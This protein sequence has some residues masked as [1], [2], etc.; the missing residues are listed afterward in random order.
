M[1]AKLI[2]DNVS[3][4]K[5]SAERGVKLTSDFLSGARKEE[6]LQNILQVVENDRR[7]LPNQRKRKRPS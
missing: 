7:N 5:D 6:N 2:I 4:V 3:V 1:K